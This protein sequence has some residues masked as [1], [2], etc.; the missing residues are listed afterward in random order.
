MLPLLICGL[1]MLISFHIHGSII[2]LRVFVIY[3][4]LC[5]GHLKTICNVTFGC[6]NEF[7][8]QI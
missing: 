2:L 8:L 4:C 1:Q 5:K 6:K 3:Y 7:V